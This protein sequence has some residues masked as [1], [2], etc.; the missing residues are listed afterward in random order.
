MI[1]HRITLRKHNYFIASNEDL[2]GTF[3][4]HKVLIYYL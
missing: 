3:K 1:E 2:K 4:I